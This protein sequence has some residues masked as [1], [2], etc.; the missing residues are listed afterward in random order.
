MVK[1]SSPFRGTNLTLTSCSL[2]EKMVIE[3]RKRSEM[4]EEKGIMT[5]TNR[6]K[7]NNKKEKRRDRLVLQG[8]WR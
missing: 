8:R 6:N 3:N 5:V 2:K 7:T 4:K 1:V